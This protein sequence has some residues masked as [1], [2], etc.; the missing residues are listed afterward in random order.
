MISL[1]VNVDEDVEASASVTSTDSLPG[2]PPQLLLLP[3]TDDTFP[4][5]NERPTPPPKP[6]KSP[7]LLL[8]LLPLGPFTDTKVEEEEEEEE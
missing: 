2:R 1:V 5:S 8:L 4:E 7:P 3:V 6:P